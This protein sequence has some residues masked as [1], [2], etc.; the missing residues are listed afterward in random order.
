MQWSLATGDDYR[1][2][3]KFTHGSACIKNGC[4]VVSIDFH[5][6]KHW[7][8][9]CQPLGFWFDWRLAPASTSNRP[10][11][12]HP[13]GHGH[14]TVSCG[15][16]QPTLCVAFRPYS[17]PERTHWMR[18][19]KWLRL[20]LVY[21]CCCSAVQYTLAAYVQ[22]IFEILIAFTCERHTHTL[23]QVKASQSVWAPC[24][25]LKH[26]YTHD[27]CECLRTVNANDVVVAVGRLA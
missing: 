6:H 19:T 26:I 11:D 20:Q 13:V 17:V 23:R 22:H 1:K 10:T 15:R 3:H 9:K 25:Q 5:D 21:C 12:R 27:Y 24:V 2:A 16:G 4:T 8:E 14:L 18:M 7:L